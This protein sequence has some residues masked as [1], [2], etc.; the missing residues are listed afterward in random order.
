MKFLPY[1]VLTF[2]VVALSLGGFMTGWLIEYN[3][4]LSD[5][6]ALVIEQIIEHERKK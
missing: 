2:W 4:K 1:P 3:Y 5:N 6:I